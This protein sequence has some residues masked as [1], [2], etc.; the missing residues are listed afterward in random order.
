MSTELPI[1]E[2]AN[3]TMNATASSSITATAGLNREE[4]PQNQ[5]NSPEN[6][7]NEKTSPILGVIDDADEGTP[8]E[9][10]FLRQ[11]DDS[12][13][14]RTK[15]ADQSSFE[16]PSGNE[17][18]DPY[19][20]YGHATMD[21]VS[22]QE[23]LKEKRRTLLAKLEEQANLKKESDLLLEITTLE[24]QLDMNKSKDVIDLAE[25]NPSST[26]T[27][28]TSATTTSHISSTSLSPIYNDETPVA[29]Q[30]AL[31]D[32]G[33]LVTLSGQITTDQA[34]A[35]YKQSKRADFTLG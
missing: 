10:R 11:H 9:I 18:S 30:L 12:Y 21:S 13:Q 16:T 34:T 2:T 24:K 7:G 1:T 27:S 32:Y 19:A 14:L 22:R 20:K 4:N 33:R 31:L 25:A 17:P 3:V 23:L 29:K 35:F 8:P 26:M 6:F 28:V 5:M 15:Q